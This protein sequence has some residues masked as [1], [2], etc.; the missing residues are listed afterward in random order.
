MTTFAVTPARVGPL[1]PAE[2]A[3]VPNGLLQRLAM[4]LEAEGVPYCQWKGHLHT[5]RWSSGRGDVDLLIDQSASP[6]FRIIL[7]ELGFRPAVLPGERELAGIEHYF[8]HDPDQA[9]LLHLHVH[10]RLVLGDFWRTTHRVSIERHVIETSVPGT[11]FRVPSPEY[12]LLIFV[13]RLV[14]RHRA[15]LPLSRWRRRIPIQLDDLEDRCQRNVL[16]RNLEL[17]LPSVDLAF[18]ERCVRWLRHECGAIDDVALPWRLHRR[19]RMYARRPRPGALLAAAIEKALPAA[20][21]RR[22]FDNRMRPAQGGLVV[23][24]VGGDGSGKTT[25]ARE[26]E[27]WLSPDFVTLRA[28][29]GNPPRSAITFVVGGVLKLQG[30]INRFR[31]DET[32]PSGRLVMARHLCAARDCYRQY[33]SVQQFAAAGG[34]AIC[35]RY[36]ISELPTHLGPTIPGL[37]PG[38]RGFLIGLLARAEAW[39]FQRI[40][41]PDLLF[42]LQLHP[43]LAVARKPDEPADYVR[44]RGEAVWNTVWKGSGAEVIDVSR[45]FSDA[46]GDL[47]SRL[48]RSL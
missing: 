17:H 31:G 35:D 7:A 13:F 9:R 41:R 39:Y 43:D 40:P 5:H 32:S 37:M 15:R 20:V 19:L 30:A 44:T 47:K 23:A 46:F 42:V 26:L 24:L 10:Y 11:V 18:F 38:T 48:W 36:P 16:S 22:L 2:P 45:P 12:Q 34:I 25:C 1:V 8:G 28:Q 4:R 27:R 21:S 6:T 29:L 14:L 3:P 33:R